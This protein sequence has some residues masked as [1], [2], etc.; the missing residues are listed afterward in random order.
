[1]SNIFSHTERFPPSSFLSHHR[2]SLLV[3][4]FYR[5]CCPHC[6]PREPEF[7]CD[8]CHPTYSQF[9]PA[10]DAYQKPLGCA[11][12]SNLKPFTMGANELHLQGALI[13]FCK[14]LA[15]E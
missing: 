10:T 3:P 9:P 13:E 5:Y 8:L 1:M 14:Q 6:A 2:G 12:K 15:A 4:I 7:C 11:R